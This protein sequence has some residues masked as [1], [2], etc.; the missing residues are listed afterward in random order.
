M[1][2]RTIRL[3]FLQLAAASLCHA[4]MA[5]PGKPKEDL[6]VELLQARTYC[7]S[8]EN[9]L[10]KVRQK[11]PALAAEVLAAE[12]SWK[13]S[14]FHSACRAIEEDIKKQAGKRGAAILK[15]MDTKVL[16]AAAPFTALKTEEDAR[17]FLE[18]V[19][20]RAKGGIEVPAVRGN[21][22]WHYKPYQENPEK[23]FVHGYTIKQE[24]TADTTVRICFEVPMSWKPVESPE[25]N[26]MG[27]TNCYGRGNVWFTV[28]VSPLVTPE[29]LP[30]TAQEQF[31][32]Y[33]R[34]SLADEYE[35]LGITLK[36]FS[37]TKVNG[38]LALMF[39]RHQPYEQLDV[40]GLREAQVVRVFHKGCMIS[41]QIN[42][43]GP[44]NSTSGAERIKRNEALFKKIATSLV[45]L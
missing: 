8:L 38:M 4:Q 33:S 15:E 28:L 22:L 31:D 2:F 45:V 40:K 39:T 13:S 24:H 26:L 12:A 27:F 6:P 23:E 21:L 10:V 41:F 30:L 43:V 29:G 17:D 5:I 19:D 36:S 11:Y 3:L 35:T 18:L 44:E 1:S 14:P 42:T 25:K 37:K 16:E 9:Q 34:E 7:I 20:I 32:L